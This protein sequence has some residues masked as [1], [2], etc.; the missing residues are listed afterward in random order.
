MANDKWQIF[1]FPFAIFHLPLNGGSRGRLERHPSRI[2]CAL[3]SPLCEDLSLGLLR[4]ALL[5]ASQSRWL[6]ERAPQYRVVRKT[7]AR[8]MPGERIDDAIETATALAGSGV[9]SMLSYL[10]ENVSDRA[11]AEAVT[12][13]YL[14]ALDRIISLGL[15]IGISIK[16]THLGLEIDSDLCYSNLA[17]LIERAHGAGMVWVDMESSRYVDATLEVYRR[18]R[19]AYQNVGVCLQ[20]YLYRTLED[21]ESLLPLG[22]SIRLVKGAY[23]EPPDLAYRHKNDVD[24]NFFVLA[25]RLMSQEARMASVRAAFA[26]HDLKL[27]GQIV[28]LTEASGA[29]KDS[30]EFQMLYGIQ[31][32]EQQRLVQAGHTVAVLIAYGEYWFPWFMRRLAER[33][34]NV[35]FLLKNI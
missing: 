11:E 2:I 4:T 22:P 30:Y 29:S 15:P 3:T 1:H 12:T 10:G 19:T 25:M 33:P 8:F 18:A 28:E 34:A 27:I 35:L 5:S 23:N 24:E 20:A 21:L 31:R 9:G 17:I 16:L 7:A 13:H 32:A 6:R 14:G 26:T